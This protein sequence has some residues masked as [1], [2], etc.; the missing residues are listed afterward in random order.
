MSSKGRAGA[1]GWAW[2]R[3]R[4]QSQD[5]EGWTSEGDEG[6]YW[7]EPLAVPMPTPTPA[8]RPNAAGCVQPPEDLGSVWPADGYADDVASENDGALSSG[9][10]Y[11]S[12]II[13]QAFRF[14]GKS[15]LSAPAKGLPTGNA[16]RTVE[17]G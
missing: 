4:S 5:L 16:D 14:N 1:G 15:Y 9:A 8:L 6:T 13:G 10:G 3:V 12:G 17:S 2:W 11:A 7:L